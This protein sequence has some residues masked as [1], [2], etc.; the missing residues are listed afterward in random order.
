MSAAI[1]QEVKPKRIQRKRAK[2]FRLPDKTLCISRPGVWGNIYPVSEFGDLALPLFRNSLCGIWNPSL[3]DGHPEA[4]RGKAYDLHCKW[5]GQFAQHPLDVL[6]DIL[7]RYHFI[8][9]WCRLDRECHGD[10]MLE[11]A[12]Q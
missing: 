7:P 2:G 6:R 4:L 9:C 11:V 1:Q 3:L 5:V 10:I 12:Y 8:A